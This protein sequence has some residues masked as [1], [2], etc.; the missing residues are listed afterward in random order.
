MDE[1]HGATHNDNN[2]ALGGLEI[3]L[4][5]KFEYKVTK[6]KQ[7]EHFEHPENSQQCELFL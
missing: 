6:L 1:E 5:N 4:P 7:L 3:K 2:S